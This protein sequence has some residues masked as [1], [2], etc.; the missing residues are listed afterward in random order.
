MSALIEQAEGMAAPDAVGTRRRRAPRGLRLVGWIGIL[1][2]LLVAALAPWLAPHDPHAQD[3][4]HTLRPPVWDGGD[5]SHPFGTDSL[6]RDV[7]S[8]MLLGARSSVVISVFAMLLGASLGV[9][10]GMAA[11]FLGRVVDTVLMRLGDIQLALPFILVAIV[12]LGMMTDRRPIHLILVLGLPAWIV[13]ARVVRSR[14]LA[15]RSQDYVLAA[16]T[17]GASRLRQMTTYVWPQVRS[18]VPPVALVDLSHLIIMESTLSFLGFGLTA[19]AVSWGQI[20]AEGRQ[21][22]ESSPWLPVLPGVAIMLAV[23]AIN[24]AAEPGERRRRRARPRRTASRTAAVAPEGTA[25][26]EG[27]DADVVLS[28]RDLRVE[29]PGRDGRAVQAVRGVSFQ[30]RRG[31]IVGIVGESGSGKSVTAYAV[32]GLLSGGGTVTGGSVR[33]DGVDLVGASEASLRPLRG[34]RLGMIFQNPS[35]SLNP[36]LT[37]GFQLVEALRS[38]QQVSRSEA[39]ARSVEALRRVGFGHPETVMARYPF[40]LSGGQNQRVMIAMT[41][42]TAPDLLLADEPTTAL[43]VTT[44]AQV[45]DQIAAMRDD[46]GTSVVLISH[47]LGL[48]AEVADEIVVMY[49]GEVCEAG[50]TEDV[51]ASP[52]HPYTR[53]LLASAPG[54]GRPRS[55]VLATIPGDLPDPAT[56]RQGCAF[57]DRCPEAM[58]ICHSIAP[59]AVEHAPA[60][61]VSCHLQAAEGE[62]EPTMGKVGQR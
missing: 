49:A 24:L 8:R 33:F 46:L 1:V 25:A 16:R 52:A 10:T 21:N 43:D 51:L 9:L 57:A 20:L 5:W 34:R 27:T 14:V 17:L 55:G 53:A 42:L 50:R 26:E 7:L 31:R 28:V 54:A 37:V 44:Q 60:W 2:L 19:P 62:S 18:V 15:E 29:F 45:L 3:I 32:M 48:M 22:M 61:A 4:A 23:L 30:V 12:V 11:G 47:D 35:S 59:P 38:S 36:V 40:R 56:T 13:Y 41:M 6:G 39:V 58:T